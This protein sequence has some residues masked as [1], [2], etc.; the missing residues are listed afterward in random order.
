MAPGQ[1]PLEVGIVFNDQM[2]S[3]LIR[4]LSLIEWSI[5]DPHWSVPCLD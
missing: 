3:P 2:N 1:R 4:F 5:L